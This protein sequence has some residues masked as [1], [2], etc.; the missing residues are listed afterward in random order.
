VQTRKELVQLVIDNLGITQNI[1]NVVI[2]GTDSPWLEKALIKRKKGSLDVKTFL[3]T[4]NS[5]LYGRIY[6]IFLYIGDVLDPA[7]LYDPRMTPDEE[8]EP[9]T[10]DR[11]NQIWSLYVDSRMERL[12]IESFF[13]RRLRKNLFIDLESGLG[14]TDAGELFDRLWSRQSFTYPEIVDLSYRLEERLLNPKKHGPPS[15]EQTIAPCLHHPTVG[16]HLDR[17]NSPRLWETLNDLLSFSA[18]SCR[19]GIIVPC[20]YGIVFLYQNKVFFELIPSEGKAVIM[21]MLDPRTERYDTLE[22]TEDSNTEEIQK[23][24]R[25]RYAQ[26]SMHDRN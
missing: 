21:T 8:K 17:L 22:V 12:G 9:A 6:R 15:I 18:Y 1:N 7:F 14:W 25:D 11:Y 23:K 13:D 26:L 10:R 4:D 16:V 5:F 19:D 24:I 20:H 2:E 3:W